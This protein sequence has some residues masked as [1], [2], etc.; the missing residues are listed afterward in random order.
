MNIV[1][2]GDTAQLHFLQINRGS[3]KTFQ[4]RGSQNDVSKQLVARTQINDELDW[5]NATRIKWELLQSNKDAM[6]AK[7]GE[8]KYNNRFMELLDKPFESP[9]PIRLMRM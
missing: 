5:C 3:E 4:S 9:L 2:K 7:Y 1:L 8:I 6:I